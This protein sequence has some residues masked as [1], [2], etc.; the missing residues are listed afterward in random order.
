MT[1]DAGARE[2]SG[3][4]PRARDAT[5]HV[6]LIGF[7]AIGRDLNARLAA[8]RP[9]PLAGPAIRQTVLLRRHGADDA[10]PEGLAAG[11][12]VVHDL[13]ALLDAHPHVVVEA[14]GQAAIREMGPALLEAGIDLVAA[15]SGALGDD[16][17]LA[18]LLA[19]AKRGKARLIV[20]SGAL[21]GL[22]YLAALREEPRARAVY[23]SR[24][25]PSAWVA[26]LAALGHDAGMLSGTVT[27]FEGSAAEAARL[28]PRNLNAGLT[29]A[30]AFGAERLTVRVV[31]DPA[32]EHNTHEIEVESP[33]GAAS[34]R[35]S[36]WPST[37]NPK[38]SA[39]TAPGLAAA[40]RRHIA[41]FVI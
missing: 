11:T 19:A 23:T 9:G 39:L 6:G 22:D 21:G 18:R 32:V 13:D 4:P 16:A 31:A 36:N 1:D 35:F 24:K 38:T 20:P 10:P 15:S 12:E 17:L 5:V 29:L 7:G 27:L 34:M 8:S 28:Y 25:P 2:A 30:L 3:P 41:T 14:A 40:V 33:L 26:E 37:L